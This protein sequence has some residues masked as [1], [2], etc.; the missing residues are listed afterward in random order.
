M[1]QLT[2][3][4]AAFVY[5]ETPRTPS[6]VL[7]IFLYDPSTAPSGEVTIDDVL[8]HLAHRVH[9]ARTLR[10]K[11][12]EVPLRLDWPYWVE[13]PDFDLEFHVRHIAL[14]APGDHAQLMDLVGRLHARALDLSRPPW[15]LYVI[16]G[17]GPSERLPQGGFAVVM[18][19]HHAA[20]DGVAGVEL[21]NVIHSHTPDVPER[22]P[23]PPVRGEREPS[24]WDL[25]G[26]ALVN[27]TATP[28]RIARTVGRTAPARTLRRAVRQLRANGFRV[29]PQPPATRFNAPVSA[30]RSVDGRVVPLADVKALRRAVPGSTVND[31][32]LTIVGGALRTYL[33]AKGELPDQTLTAMVPVSVRVGDAAEGG[34]QIS[35]MVVTLATDIADPVERLAAVKQATSEAKAQ[36]DGVDAQAQLAVSDA[37]PGALLGVGMRA[38]SR[39]TGRGPRVANTSVTNVPGSPTPLYL[40]GAK[41][42]ESWGGGPVLDGSGLINLVGS[43]CD[44]FNMAFTACRDMVPDPGFY[45]DC[46]LESFEALKS[47]VHTTMELSASSG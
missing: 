43:Y 44:D 20:I 11:L 28:V 5:M 19:V 16:E 6:H 41:V 36:R 35:S 2:L 9:E 17:L 45:A 32:A 30:H 10:E 23:A 21:I 15:E 26:R 31:V 42:V 33:E 24:S 1:R 22:D 12:V 14:P 39:F 4:D 8:A 13:D 34:N 7:P 25:L 47:A 29:P 3:M 18:K 27:T 46:L 37:L 38:A 40:C